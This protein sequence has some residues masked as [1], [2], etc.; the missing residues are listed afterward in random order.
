MFSSRHIVPVKTYVLVF[1]VLL[2]LAALTTAAAFVN[3]GSFNTV[4]ALTI[5][6][7]KMLLVVLVFMHVRYSGNLVRVILLAGFFWLALMVGFTLTDYHSRAW[8]PDPA[9]WSS[10]T[11]PTHP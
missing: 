8:I 6:C 11:P 10:L 1:V 7:A 9:P 3:L 4:V 5:A 2:F